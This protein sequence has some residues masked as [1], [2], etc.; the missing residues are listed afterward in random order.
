MLVTTVLP[1]DEKNE[2]TKRPTQKKDKSKESIVKKQSNLMNTVKMEEH[3][4]LLE[5]VLHSYYEEENSS[6]RDSELPTS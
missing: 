5:N 1:F 2:R 3:A 4:N 6:C